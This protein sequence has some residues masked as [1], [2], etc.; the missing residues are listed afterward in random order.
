MQGQKWQHIYKS[1][2]NAALIWGMGFT[3][4]KTEDIQKNRIDIMLRNSVSIAVL[5]FVSP[6]A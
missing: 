4:S 2:N 6:A 3:S 5:C 1:C